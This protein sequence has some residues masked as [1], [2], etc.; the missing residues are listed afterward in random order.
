MR[1]SGWRFD[2]VNSMTVYFYKTV[3]LNGSNYVKVPLRSNAILNIENNDGYCFIWSILA[4][5][6]PWNNN[7]PNG[8]SSY[9][10][11]F[12]ELNIQGFDFTNGF[13]C[14]DVNKFN[15]LKNLSVKIFEIIFYHDHN[16]WRYRLLLIEINKNNSDRIIDLAIYKNHYNLIKKIDV[17][18]GDNKK[19]L[20]CRQCLSSH[21]S[22]NMLM[23]HK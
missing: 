13:K 23:K 1:D 22:E 8:V 21:T 18:L 4:R 14:S 20:I 16:K 11:Y 10:Q 2:K 12:D 9:R 17:S 6:P 7:L 15:E 5:L 3:E 19:K